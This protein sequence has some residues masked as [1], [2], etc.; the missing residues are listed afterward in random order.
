MPFGLFHS[1]QLP[2][3]NKQQQYYPDALEQVLRAEQLGYES[4]WMTAHHFAYHGIVS[5]SLAVLAYLAG[6]THTIRLA[7]A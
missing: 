6:V 2:D 1:V 7:T 5:A 3:S 4:V